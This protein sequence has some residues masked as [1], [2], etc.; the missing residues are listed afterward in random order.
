MPRVKGKAPSL[1]T[2]VSDMRASRLL[3]FLL[4]LQARGH[5]TASQLADALE[6]SVRTIYRDAEALAAAGIPLR[7]SSGPEG[8]YRLLDGFRTRLTG[9]TE[10][11][12]KS[13][14][15][16]GLSGP[17][18][19]LGLGAAMAS[20][21][22]KISASL[23][24]D[25]ADQAALVLNRFH[26]DPVGWYSNADATPHLTSVA[27]AVWERRRL[28]MRYRRWEE[29]AE[30]ERTVDPYGIVLKSGRWYLV[31]ASDGSWRTYRVSQIVQL[32]VLHETF[33]RRP[34]F[35]LATYWA[36][37][38]EDFRSRLYP[39]SAAVRLS[40]A[41]R[42]RARSVLGDVAAQA[43]EDTACPPGAD[44]WVRANVPIESLEH[45]QAELLRLGPEI[46]VLEPGELRQ[47]MVRTVAGLAHLYD[48]DA[49]VRPEHLRAR[50]VAAR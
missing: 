34:C 45:A 13:V 44:G 27:A 32:E 43:I 6:V 18:A 1:T 33:E 4:L 9:L 28:R 36:S 14:F 46:E 30:V 31:A 21:Q 39:D 47:R 26:L 12:A 11:E 2:I 37:Y 20:A 15:L 49:P 23:P 35:D 16:S 50:N 10:S 24:P 41:G 3:A 19:E 22:L 8:G 42:A 17:A 38:V 5:M 7:S 48:V 40:P 29:P 25:L